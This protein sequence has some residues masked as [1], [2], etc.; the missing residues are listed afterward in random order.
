[1]RAAI[2]SCAALCQGKEEEEEEEFNRQAAMR[3]QGE[4]EIRIRIFKPQRRKGRTET[5]NSGL[6]P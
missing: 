4:Q 5:K 3:R 6:L 2:R 1:M